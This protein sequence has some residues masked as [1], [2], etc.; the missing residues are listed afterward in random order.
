M[1]L[2]DIM[3][4]DA[5]IYAVESGLMYDNSSTF[6]MDRGERAYIVVHWDIGEHIALGMK[7]SI[8]NYTN[9]ET[10]GSGDET[11]DGPHKQQWKIQLRMKF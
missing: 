10:I 9:R 3:D 7:Y 8:T 1:V 4:Y 5:R 6:F 2:F 11:I